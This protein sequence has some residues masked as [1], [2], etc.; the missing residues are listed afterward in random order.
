M[1]EGPQRRP[2]EREN[3]GTWSGRG[4]WPWMGPGGSQVRHSSAT[5]RDRRDDVARDEL[6]KQRRERTKTASRSEECWRV[7]Q[8]EQKCQAEGAGIEWGPGEARE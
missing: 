1:K 3:G 4:V 6:A 5:M 7:T 8:S 2:G